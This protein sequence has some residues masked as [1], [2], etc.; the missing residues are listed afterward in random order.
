MMASELRLVKDQLTKIPEIAEFLSKTEIQAFALTQQS[1]LCFW[2][3]KN[4]PDQYKYIFTQNNLSYFCVIAR[5]FGLISTDFTFENTQYQQLQITT[6][7][8]IIE[9]AES[10]HMLAVI[11]GLCP[12]HNLSKLKLHTGLSRENSKKISVAIPTINRPDLLRHALAGLCGQIKAPDFEVVIGVDGGIDLDHTVTERIVA[13]FQDRLQIKLFKF[14]AAGAAKTR[15]RI[16]EQCRHDYIVFLDDDNVPAP[17]ML[18][19]FSKLSTCTHF[20]ILVCPHEIVFASQ[21]HDRKKIWVPLG[22]SLSLS[23]YHNVLGDMN[24]CIKKS[25]FLKIGMLDDSVNLACEDWEFLCRALLL[26]F[27]IG[28]IPEISQYYLAHPNSFYRR[29]DRVI[30]ASRILGLRAKHD[31]LDSTL[32]LEVNRSHWT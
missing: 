4:Y 23:T 31:G 21:A 3:L 12:D 19:N 27:R 25:D 14:S 9:K 15:N 13:E 10:E 1:Y 2:L 8:S 22:G 6:Y 32:S 24:L 5:H 30:S 7:S 28:V 17:S 16:V 11:G 20:D 18:F 29:S 26:K